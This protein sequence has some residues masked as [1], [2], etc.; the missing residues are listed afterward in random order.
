V[1]NKG[2]EGAAILVYLKKLLL[3]LD[4][5]DADR[6]SRKGQMKKTREYFL[7]VS[8]HQI[9]YFTFNHRKKS[10]KII[11]ITKRGQDS[12]RRR[13]RGKGG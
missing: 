1:R 4:R 11:P 2:Y 9:V 3:E 5:L 13:R 10:T 7:V 8:R 6:K 12:E